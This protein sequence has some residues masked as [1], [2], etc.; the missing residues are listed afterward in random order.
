MTDTTDDFT[1]GANN[2]MRRISTADADDATIHVAI[3]DWDGG[4]SLPE[5]VVAAV[6]AH[7]DTDPIDLDPLAWTIDPDAL[8]AL[9]TPTTGDRTRSVHSL[10]FE[11]QGCTVTV[12]ETGRVSVRKTDRVA[13]S[14]T[15]RVAVSESDRVAVE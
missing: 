10:S 13:V 2:G 15:D 8:C 7:L 12:S 14:E 11:Y 3:H 4:R 5:T 1:D 9:F 6:S